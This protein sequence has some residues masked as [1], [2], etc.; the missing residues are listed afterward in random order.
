MNFV[1]RTT[2]ES[3]LE[4]VVSDAA[5]SCV[6]RNFAIHDVRRPTGNAGRQLVSS[7]HEVSSR[8]IIAVYPYLGTLQPM[9]R[10]LKALMPISRP[11]TEL[12]VSSQCLF[13]VIL[14]Y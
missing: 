5:P 12:I 8:H 10:G 11:E 2:S 9:Y 3:A 1:T 4:A 6:W 7:A 14:H 13:V